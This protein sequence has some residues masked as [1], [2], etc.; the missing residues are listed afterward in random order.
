MCEGALTEPPAPL[1]EFPKPFSALQYFILLG[2]GFSVR[3][4]VLCSGGE[5][6]VPTGNWPSI[7]DRVGVQICS[8]IICFSNHRYH[9]EE[10]WK[11]MKVCL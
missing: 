1:G 7:S 9:K 8:F 2:D 11:E 4:F 10:L 3:C 5:N 6:S